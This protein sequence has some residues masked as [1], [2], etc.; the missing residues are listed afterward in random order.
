[1]PSRHEKPPIA[2]RSPFS[3]RLEGTIEHWAHHLPAGLQQAFRREFS[4]FADDY[5]RTLAT[6][7]SI[8]RRREQ[9]YAMDHS[10]GLA[11]RRPFFQHLVTLLGV[12]PTPLFGTIGVLFIDIDKLKAINDTWGHSAGDRAIAAAAAII[13]DAIRSRPH[14][15]LVDQLDDEAAEYAVSRHGGDEFLVVLELRDATEIDLVALRLKDH[16][17]DAERQRACGY[18][19]PARLAASIGGVTYDLTDSAPRIPLNE[20]ARRLVAA[21]DQ[22]MYESKRDGQVHLGEARYTDR[23]VV[24]HRCQR[25]PVAD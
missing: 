24:E 14:V 10:T 1:M 2:T 15:D 4:A 6:I 13:R 12:R 21:A 25:E 18:D 3:S 9:E 20:L 19:L 16:L 8:W 5:D 22:L 23:L 7:E 11:R 17:D